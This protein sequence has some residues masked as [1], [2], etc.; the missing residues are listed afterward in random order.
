MFY[1]FLCSR[2]YV[3]MANGPD[4]L[5]EL[6]WLSALL[7]KI[8]YVISQKP[9]ISIPL[10]IVEYL[11]MAVAFNTS[12]KA[13]C[14]VVATCFLPVLHSH[15]DPSLLIHLRLL[16][17]FTF[18]SW[19]PLGSPPLMWGSPSC[20]QSLLFLFLLLNWILDLYHIACFLCFFRC[21]EV[22]CFSYPC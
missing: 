20:F 5:E 12:A 1:S 4:P 3:L 21:Q 7:K 8:N 22:S 9:W 17:S 10:D 2:N 15:P 6:S 13:C 11:A 16:C 19:T 14:W 18:L